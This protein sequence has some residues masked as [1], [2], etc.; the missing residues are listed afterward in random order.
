[1]GAGAIGCLFGLRLAKSGQ[2]VLLVHQRKSVVDSINRK[3]VKVRELNGRLIETRI[4]AATPPSDID[5]AQLVLVTVKAYDTKNVARL[6][7]KTVGSAAAVM[8]LQNGLG[9]LETLSSYLRRDSIL[10]GSTTEGALSIG[11]GFVVHTG[12]GKTWLGEL[13]GRP[14]K[15]SLAIRNSFRDAGFDTEVS[16]Y[17]EGVLWNKAIVNSVIN[18]ISALTRLAN[19]ELGSVPGLRRLASKIL[20]EGMRVARR[21]RVPSLDETPRKFLSQVLS[22]TARNKSSMLQDIERAQRTEI[23]QLNGSI[24]IIGR[25]HKLATPYNDFLTMLILGLERS[26]R[27]PN[28]LIA[29]AMRF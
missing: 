9:N 23:L 3:G 19:G 10:G 11:P 28:N 4:K 29:A 6:L 18:P 7:S 26:Q 20:R 15:R 2:E 8:S 24:S 1:M 14:S 17:I 16:K 21:A 25:R 22:S 27:K 5:N 13:N 12:R